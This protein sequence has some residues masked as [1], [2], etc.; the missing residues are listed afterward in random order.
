MPESELRILILGGTAEAARLAEALSA[1]P[2]EPITSLAG[3]TT[4]PAPVAGAVRTGGFGGAE[5]LSAYIEAKR[6]GCVIDATHPFATQITRNAIAAASATGRPLLRLERPAWQAEPGDDWIAVHN[7]AEA[8][9]MLPTGARVLLA[10]GRQHIAPFA[11]RADIHFVM[12][13]IDP[14]QAALPP[15]HELVLARPGE[16][17]S[18]MRFL[19]DR[20]IGRIVCRNSGGAASYAKIE[21]ARR[22]GLPVTM[23]ERPPLPAVDIVA[24]A[25]EAVA[26]VRL[27]FGF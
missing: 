16:C 14:P 9:A 1:L 12:R 3:R 11:A 26:F 24:T 4:N 8:A 25:A 10:L 23:I 2:V 22:L 17:A 13:M 19:A 27:L 20:K 6:I 21:A 18:E 7:E 5:G 15:D